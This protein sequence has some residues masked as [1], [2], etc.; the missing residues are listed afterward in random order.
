MLWKENTQKSESDPPAPA[1]VRND[2]GGV[3]LVAHFATAQSGVLLD[4]SVPLWL[5]LM[6]PAYGLR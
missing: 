5:W 6:G 1:F 3:S 4:I 2:R